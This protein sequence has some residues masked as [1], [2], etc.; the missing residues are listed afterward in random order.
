MGAQDCSSIQMEHRAA[1]PLLVSAGAAK[2]CTIQS[3]LLFLNITPLSFQ[4][5]ND[6][7]RFSGMIRV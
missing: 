1:H 2:F 3:T 7:F 5:N 6:F 4:D